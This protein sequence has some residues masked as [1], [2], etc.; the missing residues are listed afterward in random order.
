MAAALSLW[1]LGGL[2]VERR[3]PLLDWPSAV[4]EASAWAKDESKSVR[5]DGDVVV[6]EGGR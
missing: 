6:L 4:A 5:R 3:E 2:V 1:I